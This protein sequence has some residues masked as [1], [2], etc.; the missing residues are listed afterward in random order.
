[1]DIYTRVN[2]SVASFQVKVN[3]TVFD[4]DVEVISISILIDNDYTEL[5]PY[6]R[7]FNSIMESLDM[8]E[9]IEDLVIKT[10]VRESIQPLE[11]A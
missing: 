9:I 7:L 2:T 6:S 10:E 3:L 11:F 5:S 4:G 1:M 8:D